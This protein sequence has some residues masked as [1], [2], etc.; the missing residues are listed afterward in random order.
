VAPA[1]RDAGEEVERERKGRRGDR[2]GHGISLVNL[3]CV[4]QIGYSGLQ[5]GP[6]VGGSWL[7]LDGVCDEGALS[8]ERGSNALNTV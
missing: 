7:W 3:G 5:S 8:F 4:E 1:E 6:A 2:E